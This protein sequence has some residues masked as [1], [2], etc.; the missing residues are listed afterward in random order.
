M[1]GPVMSQLVLKS[2]RI[3]TPQG[4]V[5][6]F[7]EIRDGKIH[8]ITESYL[9]DYLDY[10]GKTL[11]PGFI[12]IHIHGWGRGSYAYKGNIESLRYMSEDLPKVGVTAYLPTTSTMPNDFLE[13]SL[14][15]AK[16]HIGEYRPDMGA[17]PIGIHMEGPYINKAYLGL[18]REDSIQQPSIEGFDHFNQLAGNQVK[19]MTLAPEIEGSLPL[20]SHLRDKGI[21]AS[22]GHT[23]ATFDEITAAIE[24]GLQHFTHAYSGMRGFHHRELGVVGALMYYQDTFAEVAKQTGITV[25]PEAFDILYRLKTDNRMVMMSDCMGYADFPDGYEFYHYLRK[26]TFIVEGGKL[27]LKHD[28]GSVKTVDPCCYQEV[29][30]LEMNYLESVRAVVDR[31][32][33]GLCSVAKIACENP[34]ILAGASDRKGK[35]ATGMDADILVLDDELNLVDV[36]CHGVKQP[37]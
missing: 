5:S 21:T 8:A 25:K 10:T 31:L 15:A 32:D 24:A 14:L 13:S 17:E 23:A 6:G 16:E 35:L 34:A 3:I 28:D 9:G 22:A 27:H 36:Y 33:H 37:L 26:E 30:G 19:L 20:I 7:V 1:G 4:E 12:D 2:D 29:A 11:M 18:Q